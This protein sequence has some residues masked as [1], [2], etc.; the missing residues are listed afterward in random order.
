MYRYSIRV[1]QIRYID[2]SSA[3]VVLVYESSLVYSM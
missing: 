3:T 2:T 1:P